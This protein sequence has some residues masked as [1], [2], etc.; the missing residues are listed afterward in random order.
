[1][2]PRMN[3]PSREKTF[4]SWC[5]IFARPQL[6]QWWTITE[7]TFS[8]KILMWFSLSSH[9][10]LILSWRIFS[11]R[12]QNFAYI[13]TTSEAL[14]YP[15][16]YVIESHHRTTGP[17]KIRRKRTKWARKTYHL[18]FPPKV[19]KNTQKLL[20]LFLQFAKTHNKVVADFLQKVAICQ[21]DVPDHAATTPTHPRSD[22]SPSTV[23][24]TKTKS[25]FQKADDALFQ[26]LFAN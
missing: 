3:Y 16:E 21:T 22:Q 26:I 2:D 1:M 13:S 17:V 10:D 6:K 7:Q 18:L 9:D 11:T 19:E 5:K 14:S 20:F 23:R 12:R 8:A 25:W 15:G 24:I 4:C